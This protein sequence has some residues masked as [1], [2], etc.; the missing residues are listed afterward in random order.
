MRF[1]ETRI[2][3]AFLVE[4]DKL[5]D[6]RGFFAR[7]WSDTEFRDRGLNPQVAQANIGFSLRRGTLR[8]MHYQVEPHQEA[9]LVRCTKGRVFDVLIDLRE[10]SS[11]RLQ[12]LGAELTSEEHNMIY[13]PE[14]CAHG[15]MTLTDD[16]EIF[17]QT[18][19]AY[20]AHAARGVR[21][22]DP[23]IAIEWPIE[24]QIV[25]DQDRR[26]P[27]LHAGSTLHRRSD[28]HRR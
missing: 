4:V 26:W 23:A 8:G 22:D 1:V 3:G 18:S 13:V 7:A 21:Y 24:A 27:L 19:H 17:Y 14:G 9:K 11:T 15:Y 12:W 5:T 20:V 25:S 10:G 16:A 6:E 2:A 28:D